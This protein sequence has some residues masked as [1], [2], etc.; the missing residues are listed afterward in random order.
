MFSQSLSMDPQTQIRSLPTELLQIINDELS[1][2]DSRR[3]RMTCSNLWN[4]IKPVPWT[5]ADQKAWVSAR[6]ENYPDGLLCHNCYRFHHFSRSMDSKFPK[7][8]YVDEPHLEC[9]RKQGM[10]LLGTRWLKFC[11]VQLLMN[12]HRWGKEHGI[13]L[14][15]LSMPYESP[16]PPGLERPDQFRMRQMWKAKVVQGQLYLKGEYTLSGHFPDIIATL[17]TKKPI[18]LCKHRTT[19]F[20]IVKH[21]CRRIKEQV[22][23]PRIWPRQLGSRVLNLDSCDFCYM[24]YQITLG[25]LPDGVHCVQFET[26]HRVGNC[27]SPGDR[28]WLALTSD[29]VMKIISHNADARG[30]RSSGCNESGSIRWSFEMAEYSKRLGLV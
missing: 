13:P 8:H 22:C 23:S 27:A 11:H 16:P 1:P 9:G 24:D 15:A 17:E 29:D 26:W 18:R 7:N 4:R 28:N 10:V 12:R 30:I 14:D 21:L 3:L 20:G 5:A 6:E 2:A 19:E 25:Y